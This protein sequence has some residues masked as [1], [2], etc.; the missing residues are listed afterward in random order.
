[1]TFNILA[2]TNE[3]QLTSGQTCKLCRVTELFHYLHQSDLSNNWSS[4][5]DNIAA[6]IVCSV[7]Y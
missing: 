7:L 2:Y 4:P 6:V 3:V 5:M 1:M